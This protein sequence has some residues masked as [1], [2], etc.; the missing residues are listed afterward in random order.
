MK[1][2]SVLGL[3]GAGGI[4]FPL[5]AAMGA[6]RWNDAGAYLVGLI[7]MVI[8]IEIFSTKIRARLTYGERVM[9]DAE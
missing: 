7:F 9:K 5:I 2:A 4:G 3:V 8:V 6:N 1:N